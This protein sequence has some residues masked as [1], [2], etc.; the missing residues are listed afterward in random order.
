M[1]PEG[2]TSVAP[3]LI[4]DDA[5]ALIEFLEQVFGAVELR[6]FPDESG[7]LMHV[8]VRIDDTVVMLADSTEDWPAAERAQVHVY[9]PDVDESHRRALGAGA[10]SVQEPGQRGDEDRRGGVTGP[11]GVTWWIA[12]RVG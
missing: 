10:I 4:V 3:Y 6:R 11:G 5:A 12:T 2:Y 1:K 7:R 9:V 8:E